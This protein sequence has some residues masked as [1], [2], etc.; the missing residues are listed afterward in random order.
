LTLGIVVH[1]A[2]GLIAGSIFTVRALVA[3]VGVASLE[4]VWAIAALGFTAGLWSLGCLV[5]VQIGYL[6][7]IYLRSL[8]E[9]MG[10]AQP[11][12]RSPHS[13]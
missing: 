6:A 2:I 3:L 9:R 13:R 10:I 1:F 11:Y 12:I 4:C 7:G 5:T 8:L